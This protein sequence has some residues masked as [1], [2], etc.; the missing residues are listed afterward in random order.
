MQS[1]Y[2]SG[3]F[4]DLER[5]RFSKIFSVVEKYYGMIIGEDSLVGQTYK[6]IDAQQQLLQSGKSN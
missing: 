3:K 1:F 5:E 6:F 2:A 4:G